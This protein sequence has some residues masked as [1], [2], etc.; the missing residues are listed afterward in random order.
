MVNKVRFIKR[1]N[2]DDLMSAIP[3]SFQYPFGKEVLLFDDRILEFAEIAD[4]RWRENQVTLEKVSDEFKPLPLEMQI[5]MDKEVEER[6]REAER[7]KESFFDGQMVICKGVESSPSGLLIKWGPGSYFRKFYSNDQIDNNEILV[8]ENGESITPREKYKIDQY[9]PVEF[10]DPLQNTMGASY[11]LI[12]EDDKALIAKRSDKLTTYP[13]RW[14]ISP[15][16]MVDPTKDIVNNRLNP[17]N[18]ARREAYEELDGTK[19]TDII[20]SGLGRPLDSLGVE[21]YGSCRTKKKAKEIMEGMIKSKKLRKTFGISE[22]PGVLEHS[23]EYFV[24]FTVEDVLCPSRLLDPNRGWVLAHLIAPKKELEH[25]Y[26]EKR[27]KRH[28]ENNLRQLDKLYM[29]FI[30]MSRKI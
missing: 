16:G 19:L 24:P 5:Y 18:T 9:N 8:D 29:K 25:V 28:L 27:V 17:F 12:T 11:L 13:N 6:K 20:I 1:K 21:I 30:Q 15:A 23:E 2:A 14:G 22:D 7:K 26:G 10:N 3:K 4:G